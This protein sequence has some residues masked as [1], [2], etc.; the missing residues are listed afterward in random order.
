MKKLMKQFSFG[1]YCEENVA[2]GHFYNFL[3]IYYATIDAH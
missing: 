1:K 3:C 2:V